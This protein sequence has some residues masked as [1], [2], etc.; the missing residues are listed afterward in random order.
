MLNLQKYPF[1]TPT[2]CRKESREGKGGGMGGG[3][4]GGVRGG[5]IEEGRG[6][7][8]RGSLRRNDLRS[9]EAIFFYSIEQ[10]L[11]TGVY[12]SFR[13]VRYLYTV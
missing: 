9:L 5:G 3:F 1:P 6:Q 4:S 8:G 7:E 12:S 2:F 13:R 10:N 11:A